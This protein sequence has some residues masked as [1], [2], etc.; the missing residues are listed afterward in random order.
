MSTMLV[1][2]SILFPLGCQVEDDPVDPTEGRTRDESEAYD[3]EEGLTEDEFWDQ[4]APLYC[5]WDQTCEVPYADD[6]DS[7]I[8]VLAEALDS[9]PAGFNSYT[10]Q[11]CLSA[12][13]AAQ[14]C[15]GD[16]ENHPEACIGI[17]D[18]GSVC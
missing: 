4:F 10:G 13:E 15:Q 18:D 5:A 3:G 7:C 12:M 16:H 8:Y 9:C 6:E 1:L 17:Y 11:A 14:E 2:F